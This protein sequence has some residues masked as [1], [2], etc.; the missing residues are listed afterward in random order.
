M[1]I[2]RTRNNPADPPEKSV[3]VVKYLS[4]LQFTTNKVRTFTFLLRMF[5]ISVQLVL[6]YLPHTTDTAGKQ[7]T[8]FQHPEGEPAVKFGCYEFTCIF[9][10]D[11]ILPPYKGSTLRGTFGHALKRVVCALKQSS[12]EKCLL[13]GQCVYPSIFEIRPV[14]G[15][16]NARNRI[17]AAP[18]PYIIEPP[19]DPKTRYRATESLTFGLILL[20]RANDCLAYF[21]YAFDQIGEAGIG[22]KIDGHAGSFILERVTADGKTIYT[23]KDGKIDRLRPPDDLTAPDCSSVTND[24][25]EIEVD[26]VTPLRVKYQNILHADLPFHV[27]TRAMLRRASTLFAA[28]GGGEPPLDYRGLVSR[29]AH[30]EVSRNNIAWHEWRRYSNRQE[31]DMLMGGM[32]GSVRYRGKLAEYLPLLNF[33]EKVHVGK[34]TTFGLGKIRVRIMPNS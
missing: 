29:A 2:V 19:D 13:A 11:A 30:V 25:M 17:A 9:K 21:I 12:C 7:S 18:H 34:A 24:D 20:G 27:L 4:S 26:L 5:C 14:S 33:C 8:V 23:K 31:Q 28:H 32:T 3:S 1:L 16:G 22:K 6:F 10:K 15:E